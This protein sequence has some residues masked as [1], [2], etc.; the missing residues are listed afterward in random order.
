M[1]SPSGQHVLFNV[2]TGT[3]SRLMVMRADG[4]GVRE[5]DNTGGYTPALLAD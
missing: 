5:L 4:T 2:E 1:Y 3:S